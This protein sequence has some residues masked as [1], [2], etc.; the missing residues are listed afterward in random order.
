MVTKTV[1]RKYHQL[2]T[3]M[4]APS[5]KTPS[6]FHKFRRRAHRSRK[7]RRYLHLFW[8]WWSPRSRHPRGPR[9]DCMLQRMLFRIPQLLSSI[10]QLLRGMCNRYYFR[11][12]YRSG[13]Q[14]RLSEWSDSGL[15]VCSGL[16]CGSKEYWR[17]RWPLWSRVYQCLNGGYCKI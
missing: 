2:Q 5:L 8:R 1:Y 13:R 15:D 14:Y 12:R 3:N 6:L 9:S 17:Y 16:W 11:Q 7:S 4:S 10:F